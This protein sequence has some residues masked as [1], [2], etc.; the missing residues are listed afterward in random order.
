MQVGNIQQL[1]SDARNGSV[2]AL[3]RCITIVENDLEGSKLLLTT[4]HPANDASIVGI[5]GPPGAGKSTL[6]NS[7]LDYWTQ[8]DKKIAILAVDPSS[9]FHHGALLGDRIRMSKYYNHPQVFIRSLASRGALGGLHPRIL[10]ISDVLRHSGFDKVIIETVGV[11]QSEVEIASLAD[12]TVVAL[13]PEA[14]DVV[15]TLKAGLMEVAEIFVVNKADRDAADSLYRNLRILAHEGM[16]VD[17]YERPV[18][19]T[20]ATNGTGIPE[21]GKAIDDFL[22]HQSADPFKRKKLLAEKCWKMLQ[23]QC[24]KGYDKKELLEK[25]SAAYAL[26]G[27]NLYVFTTQYGKGSMN[28]LLDLDK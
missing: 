18:L 5:T 10:E 15:Q 14:G 17:G 8:N 22:L 11:G 6:V 12:C 13:V 24:M 20:I 9:P 3:A 21:L 1:I 7:L 28:G 23:E 26:P 2:G 19:K 4:L 16:G 27:F 25:I